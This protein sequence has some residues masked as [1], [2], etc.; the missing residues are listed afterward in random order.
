MD[1]QFK[2]HLE[3]QCAGY[4]QR[5]MELTVNVTDRQGK[6]HFET[7]SQ[8]LKDSFARSYSNVLSL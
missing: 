5:G 3:D 8:T 4:V 6:L 1:G 7:V 2:L